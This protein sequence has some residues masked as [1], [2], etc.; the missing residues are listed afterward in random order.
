MVAKVPYTRPSITSLEVS[1]A[2]DAAA[3]GWGENCY[4]YIDRFEREFCAHLGVAESVA[5]SICTGALELGLAALGVGGGDEVIL[6]DTN[7]IASVAPVV[8]LGARPVFVDILERTWCIDPGL[9]EQAITPRTRAIIATHLYGNVCDMDALL[10]IGNRYQIPVVEDA[11]EAIGSTLH[12]RPVGTFGSFGVFSFHGSKTITTGEGGM[13]VTN[14]P[15]LAEDVR[16]LN[17]HGRKRGEHRQFFSERV[18]FKFKISNI[19]AAIGCAQLQRAGELV[20]RKQEIMRYY[21]DA[22]DSFEDL[23]VNAETDGV[24]SGAWMP[25]AVFSARTGVTREMLVEA[26][27]L[28]GIDARVFFWPL[29][30]L[31][32]FGGK[33]LNPVADRVASRSINL[34][35]FHD[36]SEPEL[37][38]V[39]AVLTDLLSAGFRKR[40]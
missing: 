37:E 29:T 1:F 32:A 3:N 35:S 20:A 30:S 10:A 17:N 16:T 24:T 34:P 12:G 39:V 31:P 2:S 28:A 40:S 26:F 36:I 6:A 9:V 14:D 33:A 13:F 11:A 38:R 25:N 5:T 21:R 23:N 7:W 4:A 27:Q 18:G 22:L 19:Q 8:H 15:N